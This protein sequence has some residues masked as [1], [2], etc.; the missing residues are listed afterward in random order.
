MPAEPADASIGMNEFGMSDRH[1]RRLLDKGEVIAAIED[2]TGPIGPLSEYT[3]RA[4]KEDLPTAT[5]EIRERV[6]QGEK[7]EDAAKDIAAKRRA[8]KEKAREERKARQV[9]DDRQSDPDGKKHHA[10]IPQAAAQSRR[11]GEASSA[12]CDG[13]VP[14]IHFIGL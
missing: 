14:C 2:A 3:T 1:S 8:E 5:A 13:Y 4:L 10:L 7:P 6:E 11:R 12:P 9:D